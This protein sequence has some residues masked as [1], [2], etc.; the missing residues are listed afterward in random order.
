MRLILASPNKKYIKRKIVYIVTGYCIGIIGG[1][2]L[3]LGQYVSLIFLLVCL[4]AT[5]YYMHIYYQKAAIIMLFIVILLGGIRL[6]KQAASYE[7]KA[8]EQGKIYTLTGKIIDVKVTAYGKWV[9]IDDVTYLQESK[10]SKFSS[11]LQLK[12][13]EEVKLTE[14]DRIKVKAQCLEAEKQMNPSDFDTPLYLKGKGISASFKVLMIQKLIPKETMQEKIK[15]ALLERI[16]KLYEKPVQAVMKACLIGV[17]DEIP[18]EVKEI[19]NQSGIGHVLAIS[20][21]HVGVM[22]NC[23]LIFLAVLKVPYTQRQLIAVSGI[24]GYALLTGSSVSTMRAA[25]MSTVMVLG[26]CLWQ[27]E[28]RY[29][30]V[31]IAAAFLLLINPYQL[32]Q[33]GFQLS[34]IAVLSILFCAY[35]IEKRELYGEWQYQKWQK[36]LIMW[37]GVQLGTAPVLA[38]HFYEVPFW[39]SLLNLVII[40]LFSMV[41]IGGWLSI[42]LFPVIAVAQLMAQCL[43]LL[44]NMIAEVTAFLLKLPYATLCVGRPSI[45]GGLLYLGVLFVLGGILFEWTVKRSYYVFICLVAGIYL[46]GNMVIRGPLKVTAL[47]VGQGDGIVMETP[48]HHMIVIDGGNVGEGETVEDYIKYHGKHEIEAIF[49]SHS[50]ADHINGIIEILEGRLKVK[51]LFI[52]KADESKLLDQLMR[53]CEMKKV[54]VTR[55]EKGDRLIV[56]QIVLTCLSPTHK[57]AMGGNDCSMVQLLQFGSF[58]AVFTGDMSCDVDG[59]IYPK[60]PPITLLKVSHHGSRTGT[61]ESLLLKLQPSYAMISCGKNNLYGH[62]HKEVVALLM[63]KQVHIARTD[64][65]GAICYETDGNYLKENKFG[66]E[67]SSWP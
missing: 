21:F 24:W 47:Y 29:T 4:L 20:G 14:N 31:A 16:N 66:K 59:L 17:D 25:I 27:E 2:M 39:I 15:D 12:I 22:M 43:T 38:Y 32:F 33:V 30:D 11:K 55:L 56:D 35:Q 67:V 52:S 46:L 36:T 37:L 58:S 13:T 60:L 9:T 45:W 3:A 18:K 6:L 23:F 8:W 63:E 62:P 57:Q 54:P 44:L 26:R 48:L 5:I 53:L 28:D 10:M 41:I 50:D 64:R 42:I 19:Y 1:N 7:I 51:H 49:L 40:P 34:F 65:E 61:D